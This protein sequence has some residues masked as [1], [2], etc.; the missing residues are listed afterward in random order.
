[1]ASAIKGQHTTLRARVTGASLVNTNV[2]PSHSLTLLMAEHLIDG[3]PS[4]IL[5][6]PDIVG[7]TAAC[8]PPAWSNGLVGAS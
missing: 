8:I 5:A 4:V 6:P 3:L 2:A 1:M 7:T